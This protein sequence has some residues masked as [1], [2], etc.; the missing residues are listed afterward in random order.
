[1]AE[2]L[3]SR[4]YSGRSA[5]E[6][7]SERREQ[8]L[9]AG[10]KIIGTQGYPSARVTDICKAA[11]VSQRY[12][13]EAFRDSEDLLL[14]L[15]ER[16]VQALLAIVGDGLV[17]AANSVPSAKLKRGNSSLLDGFRPLLNRLFEAIAAN[18]N[19]ARIVFFEVH[20]V[21]RSAEEAYL[22]GRRQFQNLLQSFV[23]SLPL[24]DKGTEPD[25]QLLSIGLVGAI[26][27]IIRTWL[28]GQLVLD[29][30]TLVER[31]LAV[32]DRFIGG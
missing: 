14:Q 28:N 4:V 3:A 21:S 29:T 1:M 23:R 7:A 27:E 20:G 12:F 17:E 9:A 13:Y 15:Y 19:G 6:R 10:L 18:P 11:G 24:N 5:A 25:Y 22:R 8:L 26:I 2:P 16:E 31:L 30:E 32:V